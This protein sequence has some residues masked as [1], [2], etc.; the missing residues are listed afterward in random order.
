MK[1]SKTKV[2]KL[3]V[4]GVLTTSLFGCSNGVKDLV[5][6]SYEEEEDDND[7]DGIKLNSYFYNHSSD[8]TSSGTN[9]RVKIEGHIKGKSGSI[10]SSQGKLGLGSG[11]SSFS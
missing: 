2:G 7:V 10:G 4:A 1:I 5:D 8:S 6:N 11:R 9:T 3:V